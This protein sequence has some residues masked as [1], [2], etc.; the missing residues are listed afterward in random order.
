[1]DVELYLDL[2]SLDSRIGV[3]FQ[4]FL[5]KFDYTIIVNEVSR[6]GLLVLVAQN[7]SSS[8]ALVTM[9]LKRKARVGLFG[10]ALS[11]KELINIRKILDGCLKILKKTL[12]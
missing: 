12:F 5:S 1:M 3:I 4:K 9:S 10:S 11:R 7:E 2:K 6:N 8:I